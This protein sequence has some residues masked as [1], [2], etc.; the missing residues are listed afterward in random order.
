[1]T[2]VAQGR[3]SRQIRPSA[4]WI[5]G[6][7]VLGLAA[8]V[9]LGVLLPHPPEAFD[10]ALVAHA[11]GMAAGYGAAVMLLI[12]SRA[13]VLERV[14]GADKLAR[15][16]GFAG[17]I[18]IGLAVAHAVAALVAWATVR[19]DGLWSAWLEMASWPGL[20]TAALGTVL[21]L[22]IGIASSRWIRRRLAYEV[23]HL[24]HLLG[25]LAVGLGFAHQLAGPALAGQRWLQIAWSLLYTYTFAVVLRYRVV[26]PLH[27]LWRHRLRVEQVVRETDD[28]VS[29]LM[30]GN[31]LDELRAQPG[32]FFRWRFLTLAHWRSAF[33]F[34]LSAPP[35]G[36]HLRI[37]IKAL[38]AGS[39]SMQDLKPG[40]L[41][42]AEGPYGALTGR[43]RRRAKVLLIAGGVGITPMRTLFESLDLPGEDVTLIYRAARETDL[44]LKHELDEVARRKRSRVIYLTGPSSDPANHLTAHS[45]HSL[46][47]ALRDHDIYL[48]ASARLSAAVRE[49]LLSSGFPRRQLHEERF[50][51]GP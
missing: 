16:H 12:M 27:Q 18:V 24:F 48:C 31:H 21:L 46:V 15:W 43:R 6:V 17:P 45:L 51:F 25:Y 5:L 19:G 49:S 13:P 10:A 36:Q 42:L 50:A 32:Q 44:V 14:V 35:S 28:V 9:A 38:G 40:D 30:R 41:V 20:V 26:Q 37:T 7:L 1:V 8:A 33:P 34:S 23:W 11:T 22:A 3:R 47:G 4:S 39:R 29:V 2:A